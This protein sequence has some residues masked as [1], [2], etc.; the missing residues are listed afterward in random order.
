M[1]VH[2]ATEHSAA[3][4]ANRATGNSSSPLAGAAR[5]FESLLLNQWL[6]GAES[7]FGAAPGGQDDEDD[8]GGDQ[9]KGLGTQQLA[10]F[11]AD[12]GGI[13][14]GRMIENALEKGHAG[15]PHAAGEHDATG[16]G[17]VIRSLSELRAKALAVSNRAAE[18]AP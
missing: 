2:P 18:L 9:M 7:S 14:I 15:H 10:G 3:A 4:G 5:D 11:L 13:G 17:D 1:H 8:A 16:S 12:S 6:Q